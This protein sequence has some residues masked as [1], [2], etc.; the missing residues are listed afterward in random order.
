M[1]VVRPATVKGLRGRPVLVT[2]AASGIGHATCTRLAAEGAL[3]ALVDRDDGALQAALP[4]ADRAVSIVADVS[5]ETAV[6]DAIERAVAELG[7]LRGV[8]TSA[9]IFDQAELL[10][11]A[12]VELDTF[13][14]T[15][16]VNLTGT[17]L[18]LK[19][20]LPHLARAGGAIVTIASTAALRGHG[21]GAG[22]TA[23]KGGV[24]A[25]TR[26][27]AVQYGD[28]NVRANCVCPGLT[29]TGM[30]AHVTGDPDYVAGASRG[31]PLRRIARPE[32]IAG[33]ICH[34][35]SDDASYVNGQIIAVDGGVTAR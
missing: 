20:A 4:R 2:G 23:S 10:P 29:A 26:L 18:V 16:A 28:Q 1:P 3:L 9:G 13:S 19:H 30:T 8:V 32:E 33:T 27:V 5:C 7:G 24:V 11:L 17:F 35:L 21:F 25:L 15:L 22:Y 34:L 31:I 12:D 6:R 14:R